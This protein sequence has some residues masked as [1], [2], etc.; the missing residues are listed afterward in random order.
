[1]GRFVGFLLRAVRA[2][3]MG[4]LPAAVII[5]SFGVARAIIATKPQLAADLPA[6]KVYIV[7]THPVRHVDLRPE[8][9]PFGEVVTGREVE[10]RALVGGEVVRVGDNFIDGGAVRKG[11]LLLEIDS[12][13]YQAAIDDGSAQLAE[14]A[15]RV[16]E[17]KAHKRSLEAALVREKEQL[18]LLKRQL[19][20]SE[21]LARRGTASQKVLDDARMSISRQHQTIAMRRNDIDAD[22]ARLIQQ[23]AR[24]A[25]IEVTLRRARRDLRQTRLLAPFDGYI[26]A[27][28]A[29]LGK[30]MSVNDRVAGLIDVKRLEVRFQLSD[31]QFELLDGA[32]KQFLSK[33]G[34][35]LAMK[36]AHQSHRKEGV[37]AYFVNFFGDPSKDKTWA[38]RISEHH[39][40]L[41]HVHSDPA[42]FGPILLGANPPVLWQKQE[43]A[44]I[45]CF[46]LLSK[47]E[48]EAAQAGKGGMSGTSADGKGILIGELSEEAAKAAGAMVDARLSLFSEAQQKKLRRIIEAAGGVQKLRLAFYGEMT[49]R[50]TDGGLANWKIEGDGFLCDY[51]SA[52]GH[53]HMTMRARKEE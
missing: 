23:Q 29:E 31:K 12:F 25:R 5:V 3:L 45:K 16:S 20:R 41:V 33:D 1:M 48:K 4:F 6:E 21:Q 49:K 13:E 32:I 22:K 2:F 9:K 44:A 26:Q 18:E 47:E 40:T 28:S 10:L 36:V 51:E 35:T 27:T 7:A 53:I 15:A 30:R 11:D 34:Y 14:A 42:R 17:Y 39:L 52:L 50:S 46:G 8:L 24:I 43:E 38:F 37:K 19:I